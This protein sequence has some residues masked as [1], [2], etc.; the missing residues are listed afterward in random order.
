MRSVVRNHSFASK[1]LPFFID[2]PESF[3]ALIK[4]GVPDILV[5]FGRIDWGES[6][7]F[8]IM[9]SDLEGR[10]I[11]PADTRAKRRLLRISSKCS[12][13]N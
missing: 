11:S 9:F 8:T 6:V 10:V 5:R 7:S 13:Q 3:S 1:S 12:S 4:E 2:A